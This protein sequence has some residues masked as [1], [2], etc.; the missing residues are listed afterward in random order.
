MMKLLR[1]PVLLLFLSAGMLFAQER[2]VSG[3]VTSAE[4]KSALPG[5][6]VILKGTSTGTATDADGRFSISVPSSG[7]TLVFSF[8]GYATQEIS[9]GTRS[10]IDVEMALDATQLGEVVVVGYG[11]LSKKELTGA[12]GQIRSEEL[13]NLPFTSVDQT[14]QGRTAGVIVTQS[15]GTPGGSISVRVR[16][17]TSLSASNEPLYVIDGVPINTGNYSS[18]GVGGQQLN[19][20]SDLNPADIESIEVLKDAASAAIYGSRAANGVVLI[21]TKRG[22]KAERTNVNVGVYTGF[23]ETWKRIPTLTGPQYVQNMIEQL[24]NRYPRNPAPDGRIPAFGLFWDE[25][26]ELGAYVFGTAT[27]TGLR[28]NGSLDVVASGSEI[29]DLPFWQNPE[30]APSTNWQNE[31]FRTAPISQYDISFSGGTDKTRYMVSG[32]YFNQEGI[33]LGSAFD[34]L[35]ARINLDNFVSDKFKIGT[36]L[37]ISR[38]R[39]NRIQNDNNI[40]GVLSTAVLM[41]TDIPVRLSNGAYGRDPVSST[42]NPVA[43]ATEIFHEAVN[44]R[45]IGNIY[46]EYEILPGLTFKS[47]WGVDL[48][49]LKE[50]QFFPST[51]NAGAGARGIG[52]SVNNQDLNFL[53]EQFLT[54]RKTFG[55]VHNI[56]AVL[57]YSQQKSSFEG[58]IA[59]AREFPSDQ[60]RRLSAGAVKTNA[61]SSG[62]EWGLNS[63][64]TRVNYSYKDKYLVSAVFRRDGSSRFG[65]NNR[66]GNFPGISAG[67]VVSE[68][69]FLSNVNPISFLK[70][71]GSYGL[72]GN[73]AI[74]DFASLGLIG[75]GANYFQRGGLA[76]TQLENPDL[77]WE[78]TKMVDVGLDLGLFRNRVNL[79]F[80]YY[81]KDTDNFLQN[82]LIPSTSGFTSYT[83]NIGS[84]RNTGM[85][86]TISGDIIS[87]PSFRWNANLN[88]STIRNTITKLDGAPFVTG[89]AGWIQEGLPIGSFRGFR[90]ERIF[91]TQDEINDLNS[92]SPTGIYQ[93][94]LTRPGDIMF[95]DINGDGRI[96]NDDQEI[97]G[98]PWPDFFGGLTNTFT[99][100]NFDLLVFLQFTKG[101][102]VWNHTRVFAEGMNSV[103]GQFATTLNSW[104]P[105]NPNTNMP[106]KVYGDPN[107]NRRNSDRWLEDG[108]FLRVKNV[109]LGYNFPRNITEKLK[110]RSLRV[111]AAGQNLLTF[112]K[113]SG[114][115][116]EVNTFG[117]ANISLGTDFLT[118]PQARTITFG[119]NVGL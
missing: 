24:Q 119:L 39:A 66:Y 112:T 19:A 46:G 55:S 8:I 34:R 33:I 38:S 100:K 71:R 75:S 69:S 49:S 99:Y 90:V 7:G 36:S 102:D 22:K 91:Q 115:D 10:Q 1:N 103:F 61:S 37:G 29:R 117:A 113:Y 40:Y 85:E 108:S 48:L 62:T 83:A 30:T 95:K 47:S 67:W 63:I 70:I 101:N 2:T 14:L 86:I 80:D 82:L 65:K 54:Y 44:N 87:T 73:F 25:W 76:P 6:N 110:V 53:H 5:V 79:T 93:S 96:T 114:F 21:T 88:V 89:F 77:T 118:F 9:I 31:I 57:G 41:A 45:L 98:N 27:A 56:N 72:T 109:S 116:P 59:Q 28:S 4:D 106:R 11:E 51:T 84:M 12:V 78:A 94:S 107:N 23:Q 104:T 18:I 52:S 92:A 15:S 97:L 68:E 16:G 26:Y 60:I 64:F 17:A 42:E 111:Y 105:E 50:D 58:L 81:V 20:L 32:S 3:R 74:G 43:S 13:R 35:N